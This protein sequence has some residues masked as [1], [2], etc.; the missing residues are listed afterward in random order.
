MTRAWCGDLDELDGDGDLAERRASGPPGRRNGPGSRAWGT[1]W[2]GWQAATG[3]VES[4]RS[5]AKC[6]KDCT[7]EPIERGREKRNASAAQQASFVV[8][9]SRCRKQQITS[10]RRFGLH[11]GPS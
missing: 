9:A 8:T 4:A 10:N 6:S 3:E 7:T 11:G 1:W 5:C 2:R